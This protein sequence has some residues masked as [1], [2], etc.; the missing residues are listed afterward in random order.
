M[1]AKFVRLLIDMKLNIANKQEVE[2]F[3]SLLKKI[4]EKGETSESD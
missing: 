3:H 2:E 1:Y 4:E